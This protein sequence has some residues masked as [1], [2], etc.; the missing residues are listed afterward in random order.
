MANKVLGYINGII[1][2]FISGVNWLIEQVNSKLGTDFNTPHS[3]T[4]KNPFDKPTSNKNVAEFVG[5]DYVDVNRWAGVGAEFAA[6]FVRKT[7]EHLGFGDGIGSIDEIGTLDNVGEVGKIRDD[8]NIADEDLK[9]LEDLI[10]QNR[11]NQINVT[12]QTRAPQITNNNTINNG[13]DFDEFLAGMVD[14]LDEAVQ[15]SVDE[16][17]DI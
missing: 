1:S 12:V 6:G 5:M 4:L 2:G 10:I 9:L 8:V 11:V 13:Q 17:Y 15:V 7:E 16:D 14:G 3:P